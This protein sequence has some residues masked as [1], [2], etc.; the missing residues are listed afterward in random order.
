MLKWEVI[1][2][3]TNTELEAKLNELTLRGRTV[4]SVIQAKGAFGPVWTVIAY[5][6]ER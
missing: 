5:G 1:E 4:F 6:F 3:T 2:I